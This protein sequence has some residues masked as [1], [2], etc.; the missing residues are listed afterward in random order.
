MNY[1]IKIRNI[2]FKHYWLHIS[3]V[4]MAIHKQAIT[5]VSNFNRIIIFISFPCLTRLV[6]TFAVRAR[7][8]AAEFPAQVSG[9]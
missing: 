5:V 6:R 1:N 4:M 7:L 2:I 9:S 3:H 8:I